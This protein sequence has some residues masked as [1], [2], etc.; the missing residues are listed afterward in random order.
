MPLT[1]GINMGCSFLTGDI[2]NT[3]YYCT[4]TMG[5]GCTFDKEAFGYC[6]AANWPTGLMNYG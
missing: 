5:F 4:N 1:Y 2:S 6:V 3:T